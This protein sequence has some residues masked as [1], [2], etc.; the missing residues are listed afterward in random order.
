MNQLSFFEQPSANNQ[1]LPADLL[2]Y[3]AAFFTA[4]ESTK[5]LG[6]LIAN[7]VWKQES[8][9]MYGKLLQ[10]PRLTAWY[11]DERSIYS[12]SGNRFHPHPWTKD[13]LVIKSRVEYAAGIEFNSV[14]LNYYRNGNDSVAWHSDDEP[15]LGNNPTIASVSFGQ[16][17]R[18]DLRYKQDHSRKYA[19]ELDNGSLLLMKGNL[20]HEWQHRIA[21]STQPM[22][23][24]IN[25]TFRV[26][27]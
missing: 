17:R 5:F 4:E 11:G 24:R 20:Q 21:K 9:H 7:T 16:V 14:L 1:Q 18:F 22:K 6:K 10:T 26:I 15:E 25:L 27:N 19:I 8:I 3:H 23:E 12:F 2:D 13:L